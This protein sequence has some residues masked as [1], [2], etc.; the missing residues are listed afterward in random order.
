MKFRFE[1]MC[2]CGAIYI[3]KQVDVMNVKN[4]LGL[5][6]GINVEL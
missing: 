1:D 3:L 2:L 4:M 5:Q 6:R